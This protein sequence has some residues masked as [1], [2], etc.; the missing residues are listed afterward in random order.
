MSRSETAVLDAKPKR[1]LNS[2]ISTLSASTTFFYQ[3]RTFNKRYSTPHMCISISIETRP[4]C[5][6]ANDTNVVLLDPDTSLRSRYSLS[7]THTHIQTL[8][9]ASNRC[10]RYHLLIIHTTLLCAE[11]FTPITYFILYTQ[12]VFECVMFC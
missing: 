1:L 3:N 7:H 2:F 4:N 9:L 12:V 5:S 8:A 10:L 11:T 6:Q